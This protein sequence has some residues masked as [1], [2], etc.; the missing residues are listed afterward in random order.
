MNTHTKLILASTLLLGSGAALGADPRPL[1]LAVQGKPDLVIKSARIA[2]GQVCKPGVPV[3]YVSAEV[4]NIGSAPST[5]RLDVAMVNALDTDGS[6]WGNGTGL[7]MLNPGTGTTVTFPIVYLSANPAHMTGTHA[8]N[9]RV[10]GAN[11]IVESN[12]ANNGFGPVSVTIPPG[13]C[14]GGQTSGLPDL[15]VSRISAPATARAGDEIGPITTIEVKN[16]GTASAP[17]ASGTLDPANAYAL[18]VVL[19]T[20]TSVAPGWAIYSP[21]FA[22]DVLL[23]GGRIETFDLAPS[24]TAIST[25]RRGPGKIPTDTRPGSYYLCAQV[26]PANKVAERN[27]GN[28]VTCQRIQ[29]S[30]SNGAPPGPLPD[31]TSKRGMIFGGAGHTG[32]GG[33]FVTWGGSINLTEADSYERAP[34]PDGSPGY[35]AF[36]INYDLV[37]A[38]SAPVTRDFMVR[39]RRGAT[40]AN[41][42]TLPPP[43]A[44]GETRNP[45]TALVLPAGTHKLNLS[46]DDDRVISESNEGN[47]SFTVFVTVGGTCP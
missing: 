33:R 43:F 47:N 19:S 25:F 44:A 1:G 16:I 6:G 40:L 29:I 45:S 32:A 23:Q 18:D 35:C 39:I 38:G 31:L 24:A 46:L 26:D 42:H 27:E 21:N 22:E 36:R 2:I 13:L 7:G 17:G 14:G 4:A 20:D 34:R 15:I 12:T 30:A 5:A 11:W 41:W 10:N 28:N 37:N 3:L 9:L 8:F